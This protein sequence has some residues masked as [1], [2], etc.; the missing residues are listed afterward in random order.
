MF[1]KQAA[2][3]L[4][5][6][7]PWD[8]AID[9]LPGAKLP[10]GRVSPLSIPERKQWRSTSRRLSNR[11][12]SNH[13][14]HPPPQAS[15]SWAKGLRLEVMH[16]LPSP[17]LTDSESAEST[18]HSPSRP[19]N[20]V[21]HAFSPSWACG[22][23]ITSF[24]SGRAMSGRRHLSHPLATMNIRSCCMAFP[25][26]RPSSSA[27]WTRYSGS[28]SISSWSS[29]ST[30]SLYTPGTWSNIATMWRRSIAP[31]YSS[32]ATISAPKVSR[33]TRGGT[34]AIPRIRQLL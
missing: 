2:T 12:S 10:K 31:L 29:T 7:R 15:S 33:W 14:H 16:W 6:H 11:D 20:S 21:G 4:P 9:L 1:S 23:H 25:T 28:S 32:S 19:R 5:S 8:S 3:R 17:E 30:T 26:H 13:L 34:A 22:S 18:F 24:V 27:S